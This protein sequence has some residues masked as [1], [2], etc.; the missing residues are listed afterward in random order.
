MIGFE[1]HGT[2]S[3]VLSAVEMSMSV[4]EGKAMRNPHPIRYLFGNG[5]IPTVFINP[6]PLDPLSLSCQDFRLPHQ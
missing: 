3:R 4:Q 5:Y 6:T 2:G 1:Q